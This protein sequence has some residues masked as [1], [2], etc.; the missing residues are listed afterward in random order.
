MIIFKVYPL[1]KNGFIEGVNKLFVV[2]LTNNTNFAG[3]F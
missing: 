1:S 3:H 2:L